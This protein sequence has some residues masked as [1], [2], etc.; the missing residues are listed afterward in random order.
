[1]SGT[2]KFK[3]N[4]LNVTV[5]NQQ[6]KQKEYL[7]LAQYGIPVKLEIGAVAGLTPLDFINKTTLENDI[8]GLQDTLIPLQSTHTQS[9]DDVGRPSKDEDELSDSGQINKD[10]DTDANK[11]EWLTWCYLL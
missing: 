2:Y 7:E 1:M 8:L 5:F 6:D 11:K 4:M 10:K 3:V 9:K